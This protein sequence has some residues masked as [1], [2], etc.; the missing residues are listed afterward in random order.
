[1]RNHYVVKHRY[2]LIEYGENYKVYD[3]ENKMNSKWCNNL[4]D[5]I[6]DLSYDGSFNLTNITI[7][8][9]RVVST[10]GRI[11]LDFDDIENFR[12]NYPE[13]FI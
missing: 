7:I 9:D 3:F 6:D 2:L 10:E 5:A 13:Y 4:S 8:T 12:E 11:I 1:M